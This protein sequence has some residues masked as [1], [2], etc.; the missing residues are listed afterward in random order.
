LSASCFMMR[1]RVRERKKKLIKCVRIF[2]GH[3][4]TN[5][6]S[7]SVYTTVVVFF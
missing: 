4:E 5:K 6:I 2:V 1:M 7:L 3:I